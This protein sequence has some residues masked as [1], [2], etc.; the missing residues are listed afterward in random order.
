MT[1]AATLKLRGFKE[2][3]AKLVGRFAG[4]I[5]VSTSFYRFVYS[6]GAFLIGA[7]CLVELLHFY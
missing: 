4:A 1:V 7:C 5:V 2:D 3:F 6:S